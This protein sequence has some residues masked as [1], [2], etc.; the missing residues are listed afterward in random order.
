M[1]TQQVLKPLHD[2]LFRY[3]RLF[4]DC[5]ATFDQSKVYD[6]AEK[7]LKGTDLPV[8]SLDL[9]AATDKLPILLQEKILSHMTSEELA[10]DWVEAMTRLPF[11]TVSKGTEAK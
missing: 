10:R 4:G 8:F 5:D 2:Y 6:F 11:H 3:L 1:F 7:Y 9:S